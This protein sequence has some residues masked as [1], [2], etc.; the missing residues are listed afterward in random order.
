MTNRRDFLKQTGLL[1]A[2]LMTLSPSA[3]FAAK[4]NLK[5][6]L[7][8]YT[9]RDYI[10]KDV[11]GVIEKIAKAGYTELETYGY[12]WSKKTYFGMPS[13]DFG[14]LLKDNGIKSPSGHY[15]QDRFMYDGKD[16]ELSSCIEAANALGQDTIVIPAT[17]D[18]FRKKPEDYKYLAEALNKTAKFTKP[19]GVK[20][21]YHNHDFEFKQ[22][23]G[24]AV[25]DT[26]LKETDPKLVTFE[27]DIYWVVRAGR[28]PIKMIE[29]NPGRFSMWHVKDMDKNKRE[30]N[31]EVGTGSI[32]FKKI[33][34]FQKKS[35]VKHIFMEQENFSM[36][37]FE[38]IT[39]SANYIKDTLLK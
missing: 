15:G 7:Q 31:T 12:D 23:D 14:A 4:S 17:G 37:G 21:G 38:S 36:D 13:K 3:L 30:L 8:L 20:I 19:S 25:Y 35:G 1:S 5:V 27:M 18:K 22:I 9:L 24:S 16:D 28:D 10:G 2:G 26:M 11:K 33:F 6:G 32:D 29:E 34:E 39:Q